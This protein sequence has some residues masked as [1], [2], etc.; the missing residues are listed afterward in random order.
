MRI[1]KTNLSDFSIDAEL[2]FPKGLI[3]FYSERHKFLENEIVIVVGME[4]L[5][6]GSR[7]GIPG[8]QTTGDFD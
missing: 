8:L 7:N 1:D 5:P 3:R 4:M 6:E 2:K